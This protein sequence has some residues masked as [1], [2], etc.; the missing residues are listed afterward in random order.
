MVKIPRRLFKS[1]A[2]S[3][4]NLKAT[5]V[6]ATTLLSS[7]L[8][9]A[10][11]RSFVLSG[12]VSAVSADAIGGAIVSATDAASRIVVS[13]VADDA[14]R[15]HFTSDILKPGNYTLS[16]RA[17]GYDLPADAQ[18]SVK[19]GR[20][21]DT[22]LSLRPTKDLAAQLTN[23][24]WLR[25]FPGATSEK[26]LLLECMSCHTLERIARS[27]FSADEFIPILHLMQSFANNTIQAHVQKRVAP[28]PTDEAL[29]RQAADYLSTI[30]LRGKTVWDYK[31]QTSPRPS[32]RAAKIVYREYLLPRST[33]APHDLFRDASGR[34]WFSEF[35]DPKLGML[36][37]RDGAVKEYEIPV[38]KAGSPMGSLDLEADPKGDLWLALMFQGG[39][40]QFDMKTKRFH[41]WPLPASLNGDAAQQSMVAPGAWLK[42]GKVWSN[43]VEKHDIVRLDVAS[44]AYQLID[45]FPTPVKGHSHSP[46]GMM[47]DKQNNL[48][49][50]DFNDENVVKIDAQTLAATIYPTP[51]PGSRPRR[52]MLDA[53]GRLW[54]AEFAADRIGMFD[55]KSET[56]K[57]W[58]TPA[59]WT[60]PYDAAEDRNGDVWSVSMATDQLLRLDPRTGQTTTYA[61]PHPTNA[62]RLL[63]DNSTNP[64]HIWIGN[65]HHAAIIEA[66]PQD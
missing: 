17:A 8:A 1:C 28:Q 22:D 36:D 39:V 64:P 53:D 4:R 34:I 12:R 47:A 32:G 63:V 10:A 57:E 18:V 58:P 31:L 24:E 14:G 51:T 37:P 60:A 2:R 55:T 33:M 6:V 45:P 59:P 29:V 19:A 20:D 23:A 52:G 43:A 54:F 38:E 5:I 3:S 65:N 61:L 44:G 27:T 49:F 15:Y 35:T 66:I 11:P 50:L 30:N 62:R 21:V 16:V 9:F 25:S 7:G 40:A 26:K 46:Y 48:W 13:V 42:D 41:V 56:F